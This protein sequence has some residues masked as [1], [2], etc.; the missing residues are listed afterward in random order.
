MGTDGKTRLLIDICRHFPK[1]LIGTETQGDESITRNVECTS[2]AIGKL[3]AD[4]KGNV[5][6]DI[7]S[8]G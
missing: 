6:N 2:G 1:V 5:G 7:E 4:S 8:C 3:D